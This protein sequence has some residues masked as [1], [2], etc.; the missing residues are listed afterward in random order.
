VR[1]R[2]AQLVAHAYSFERQCARSLFWPMCAHNFCDSET[3]NHSLARR[4]LLAPREAAS[5]GGA[6]E[7]AQLPPE[8]QTIAG[9]R[10]VGG[11]LATLPSCAQQ[12]WQ[13]LLSLSL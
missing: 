13:H 2:V 7:A 10:A 4:P 11:A 1:V 6:M 8:G 9:Q 12:Q 3:F 5:T